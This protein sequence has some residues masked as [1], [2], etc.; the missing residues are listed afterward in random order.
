[1][2]TAYL[3]S[4]H[5]IAVATSKKVKHTTVIP[6]FVKL[7]RVSMILKALKLSNPIIN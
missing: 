5:T 2:N 7:E 4:C 3:K 1:M 6:C